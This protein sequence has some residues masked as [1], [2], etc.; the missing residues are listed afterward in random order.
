MRSSLLLGVA[1]MVSTSAVASADD[2]AVT[3]SDS[4]SVLKYPE[5][6]TVNIVDDQFGVKVADPYRWLEDDVRVS[7][8][9]AALPGI[10]TPYTKMPSLRWK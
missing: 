10:F 1:F 3:A 4:Y 8:A 5:T 2:A 9:V 7:P 6:K